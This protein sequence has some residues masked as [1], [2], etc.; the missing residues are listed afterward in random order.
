MRP[1]FIRTV[2]FTIVCILLGV[3]IALQMKNVNLDQAS[4]QNLEEIQSQL[5]DYA[6]RNVE[7]QNRNAEL[8]Q[9]ISILEDDRASGSAQ[10]DSI[11]RE[12][13]RAAIFAGLREVRNYG[14]EITINSS[15]D[16]MV[17]DSVLRQFINELRA[18]GAQAISVNDERLVSTSEVR[19]SGSVII[20]NGTGYNRRS[21]FSIKAIVDPQQES[22]VLSYLD[23][24]RQSVL[25]DPQLMQDG[26]EISYHA[27]QELT[28]PA[29]SE[30]S[31][32]FKIDLLM[33]DEE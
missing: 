28:V 33:P 8:Y 31:I 19:A 22:Y 15:D 26:Y 3:L 7:L 17:R 25:Q 1:H 29:L 20:I 27:V 16:S 12:K 5:I 14:I 9:Y 30:D 32:A 11:V 24:V 6:S 23:S 4:E 2:S 13:E 21:S 10:I 18:L